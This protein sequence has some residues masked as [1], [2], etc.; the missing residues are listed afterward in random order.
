MHRLSDQSTT[1]QTQGAFS[2]HSLPSLTGPS[3]R[4]SGGVLCTN[5]K[6]LQHPR[7]KPNHSFVFQLSVFHSIHPTLHSFVIA[8]SVIVNGRIRIESRPE[9]ATVLKLSENTSSTR[10]TK[11]GTAALGTRMS[12]KPLDNQQYTRVTLS[13]P[14]E[15]RVVQHVATNSVIH[16]N[17]SRD[18]EIILV[19]FGHWL[20]W[21]RVGSW[22]IP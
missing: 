14:N 4:T 8:T 9:I 7:T 19:L 21:T 2:Y 13:W 10:T 15:S 6:H 16:G 11:Q 20:G 17:S 12:S 18:E 1:H 5:T 3:R 22:I